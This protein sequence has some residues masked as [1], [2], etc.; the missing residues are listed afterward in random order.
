MRCFKIVMKY[1]FGAVAIIGIGGATTAG[2]MFAG[3]YTARIAGL[4]EGA[5]LIFFMLYAAIIIGAAVG[6]GECRRSM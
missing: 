6:V 2:A 5:G 4:P 1:I 3:V